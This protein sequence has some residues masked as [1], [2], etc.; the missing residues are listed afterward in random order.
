MAR[1]QLHGV[2]SLDLHPYC[3][4]MGGD[5]ESA[6]HAVRV[7]LMQQLL[8]GAETLE[9]VHGKGEGKLRG[10]VHEILD[11][12]KAQRIVQAYEI[13]GVNTGS[14]VIYL[15]G[16]KAARAKE[17]VAPPAMQTK[18]FEALQSQFKAALGKPQPVAPAPLEAP[19]P[20]IE[21]FKPAEL[22]ELEQLA[23]ELIQLRQAASGPPR[24]ISMPRKAKERPSATHTQAEIQQNRDF[25][26]MAAEARQ[27]APPSRS[28]GPPL[29]EVRPPADK[30]SPK[31]LGPS[32]NWKHMARKRSKG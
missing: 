19:K 13:R 26:E 16:G 24:P 1:F 32:D 3:H 14:T 30:P 15:A 18:P 31:K 9:I 29:P 4:D 17:I 23:Q 20:A 10:M 11:E 12:Y 6:L 27:A 28:V 5:V 7:F 2:P 22:T 21:R 8:N 25:E